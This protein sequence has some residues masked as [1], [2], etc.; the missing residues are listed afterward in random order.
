M[1]LLIDA[2]VAIDFLAKREPFNVA[3]RQVIS[4]CAKKKHE[5]VVSAGAAT[6]IYY[7]LRKNVGGEAALNHIKTI[8]QYLDIVDTTKGDVQKALGSDMPDFEDAVIAYS[9]K[10]VKA[11]MIITRNLKD[12]MDSPVP[13][14]SPE[15]FLKD[16]F[17]S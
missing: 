15:D 6:T 16:N 10:R 7:V 5:G 3:A 4:L 2:N 12:Y 9:A 17:N 13:A 8:L 11:D 1:V 14:M